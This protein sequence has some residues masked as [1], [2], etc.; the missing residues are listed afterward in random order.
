MAS[1]LNQEDNGFHLASKYILDFFAQNSQSN[2]TYRKK[3]ELKNALSLMFRNIFPYFGIYIVGSSANGFG[4]EKSDVDVCVMVSHEEIDQKSEAVHFLRMLGRA[5]RR[6]SFIRGLTVISAKVPII[7]F[8]DSFNGLECDLNIN[9]HIGIRN[10]H[11]LKCYSDQDWRVKPLILFIKH[12]AK[13]HNINDA[14][15]RT[16]SSYSLALMAIYYLQTQCNPVILPVLQKQCPDKFD[17]KNDVRNLTLN[18]KL[19]LFSSANTESLG[20]L[21]G[22]FLD[23][24]SKFQFEYNVISIREGRLIPKNHLSNDILEPN[25]QF[26]QW[27]Y[28]LI[29]E[30]FDHSNT[31]RSVYDYGVFMEIKRVF[32]ESATIFK[33]RKDMNDLFKRPL[34]NPDY[35]NNY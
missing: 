33:R 30:P 2:E 1:S 31:A 15:N 27:K 16:V 24:Y 9:N 12:W 14:P 26:S 8:H 10:T 17:I 19:C 29:E 23:F 34:Y 32:K 20:E 6:A 28:I 13:F 21:F 4:T 22:G 11:L 3:I 35:N 25:S 5:L 18:E 7:K